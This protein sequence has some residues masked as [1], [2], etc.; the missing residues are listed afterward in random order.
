LACGPKA[1]SLGQYAATSQTISLARESIE[2]ARSTVQ[3]GARPPVLVIDVDRL[4]SRCAATPSSIE[5]ASGQRAKGNCASLQDRSAIVCDSTFIS[6]LWLFAVFQASGAPTTWDDF[7]GSTFALNVN[8]PHDL[9]AVADMMTTADV[10]SAHAYFDAF[11]QLIVLHEIGHTQ[12]DLERGTDT[13]ELRADAFAVQ[14]MSPHPNMLL[15]AVNLFPLFE[16]YIRSMT[17]LAIGQPRGGRDSLPDPSAEKMCEYEKIYAQYSCPEVHPPLAARLLHMIA[18]PAFRTVYLADRQW[19]DGYSK[20]ATLQVAMCAERVKPDAF[21]VRKVLEHDDTAAV[22]PFEAPA[23]RVVDTGAKPR[24]TIRYT[25]PI[26]GELT[27]DRKVESRTATTIEGSPQ[28]DNTATFAS[29]FVV[30]FLPTQQPYPLCRDAPYTVML[31]LVESTSCE[32]KRNLIYTWCLDLGG[33]VQS[34]ALA[35]RGHNQ[36]VPEMDEAV[37]QLNNGDVYP[38]VVAFPDEP[39]GVGAIWTIS[40]SANDGRRVTATKHLVKREGNQL[41]VDTELAFDPPTEKRGSGERVET[42]R[43]VAH[44]NLDE[45]VPALDEHTAVVETG[46]RDSQHFESKTTIDIHQNVL[47]RAAVKP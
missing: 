2:R 46:L 36:P 18:D 33:R 26:D 44:V 42:R 9:E 47:R 5:C 41:E 21:A 34:L 23:I 25:L 11:V 38:T 13:S 31:S 10:N 8:K 6:T 3:S 27:L 30:N 32:L 39:I 29:R 35:N 12:S 20:E 14:M 16:R 4:V 7:F 45:P 24:A 40:G 28:P 19:F 37:A 22:I 43:I 17:A 15:H 1:P